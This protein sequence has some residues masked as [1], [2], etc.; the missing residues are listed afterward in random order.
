MREEWMGWSYTY[1]HIGSHEASR[2]LGYT[3]HDR[4]R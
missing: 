4:V 1:E 2:T 3:P